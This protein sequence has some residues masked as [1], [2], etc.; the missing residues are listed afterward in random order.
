MRTAAGYDDVLDCLL[1]WDLLQRMPADVRNIMANEEM[2]KMPLNEFRTKCDELYANSQTSE[3]MLNKVNNVQDAD[4]DL[5]P[6]VH[7][8]KKASTKPAKKQGYPICF[9]HRKYGEKAYS[10]GDPASCQFKKNDSKNA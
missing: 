3:E 10:C 4:R 1:K 7:L 2:K 8:V 5:E 9:K 6:G